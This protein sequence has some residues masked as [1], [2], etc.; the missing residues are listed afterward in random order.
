MLRAEGIGLMVWSPLAGGLLSGKFDRSGATAE[1]RRA[2][3][4]FPPVDRDRAFDAIDALRGMAAE[5][6]CTVARVAIA[7]LL[8]Q[9]VVTTV[10]VGARR[11]DQLTDNLG[12]VGVTLSEA[13]LAALD[14]VTR[15]PAEY[16]GWMLTRQTEARTTLLQ[17]GA[18]T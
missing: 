7:W 15:L 6:G 10:I 18:A 8:H 9:K 16:P 1:G 17:T 3:F 2:S 11:V 14:A 4:D 5:K 13:E 12:A